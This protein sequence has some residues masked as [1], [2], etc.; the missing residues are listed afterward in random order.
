MLSF[1]MEL[2]CMINLWIAIAYIFNFSRRV[3]RTSHD[4]VDGRMDISPCTSILL[5]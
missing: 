4:P 3:A 1:S 2:A 5:A